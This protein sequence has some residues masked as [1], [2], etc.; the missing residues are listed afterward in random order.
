[1]EGCNQQDF[2]PFKCSLCSKSLCLLHRSAVSHSCVAGG[3]VDVIS[4][5]CPI[6]GKS[7]KMNR[8]DDPN[9]EWDRH[10]TTSCDHKPPTSTS[11]NNRCAAPNCSTT[12]GPSNQIKCSLCNRQ[13]CLSH[14]S[15]EAH[16]CKELKRA[17]MLQ[18]Q[19]RANP[20]LFA[21]S[22][23][24]QSNSS[25]APTSS[26]TKTT[27]I[28]SQ[29][30]KSKSNPVD[31]TNTLQ[32]TAHRRQ[33]QQQSSSTNTTSSLS[34]QSPIEP[35]PICGE[36]FVSL[37]LLTAH[38]DEKHLNNTNAESEPALGPPPFVESNPPR[39]VPTQ[40]G[41]VCPQCSSRYD[42]IVDL[43]QHVER[44]HPTKGSDNCDLS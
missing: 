32:G 37:Q 14:R 30:K 15:A 42:N 19:I 1:M 40:L 12:L 9:I 17:D 38:L 20:K 3:I 10:F 24:S 26:S 36:N 28:K 6:C 41:E 31:P 11:T 35:C 7:I 43:I 33:Q 5:A 34:S 25:K 16:K 22:S 4:M 39:M 13:V 21:P 23:A 2:L 18:N 29:S 8:A 27:T 44:D